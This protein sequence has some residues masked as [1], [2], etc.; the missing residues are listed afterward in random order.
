MYEVD[1]NNERFV[2]I[3]LLN[4]LSSYFFLFLNVL[5]SLVKQHFGNDSRNNWMSK[6]EDLEM[7][8]VISGKK[9][10]NKTV[11]LCFVPVVLYVDILLI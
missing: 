10:C 5:V 9:R 7:C 11:S 8:F 3:S 6:H 2:V 4:E 1:L